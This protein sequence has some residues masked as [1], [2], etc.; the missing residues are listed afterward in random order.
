MTPSRAALSCILVALTFSMPASAEPTSDERALALTL[1]AR[2]RT[3][4]NDGDLETAC[5]SFAESQRLDPG[6]G[7]LLN[8]AVCHER[9]GKTATAWTEYSEAL[10]AARRD[11]RSDRVEL[12]LERK[13]DLEGRLARLEVVVPAGA[14]REGLRIVRDGTAIPVEAWGVAVPVDPGEHSV[15]AFLGDAQ[16]FEAVV[17]VVASATETVMVTVGP[18]AAPSAPPPPREERRAPTELAI[19]RTDRARAWAGWG[20]V[21]GGAVLAGVGTIFGVQALS[22]K[23]ESDDG[24]IGGRCSSAAVEANDRAKTYADVSTATIVTAAVAVGVGIY[25]LVTAERAAP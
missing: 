22:A 19:P 8:L 20:A 12:A 10:A 17:N 6:G 23:R 3:A 2:G 9:Q 4:M 25:L 5:R 24:C 1:F 16:V 15:V 13:R 18:A 11:G 14:A 7:T 21:G